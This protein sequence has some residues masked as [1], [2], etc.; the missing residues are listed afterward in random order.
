MA[1]DRP[2]TTEE[3]QKLII[4]Q[5]D[6]I[7]PLLRQALSSGDKVAA[8]KYMNEM[9]RLDQAMRATAEVTVGGMRIPVGQIGSGLQSGISGLLTGLPDIAIGATNLL[10]PKGG[11][12]PSLG[13]LATK[14]L[15]VQNEPASQ[16]TAYPFRIAQGIGSAGIPGT[17]KKGLLLGAALP[18][19][20]VA[21]SQ[22]INLPEGVISGAYA[23]G[24]LTRAGWKGIKDLQE[25][26]KFK[27]FLEDNIPNTND[28]N[29]FKEFMLRGQG[30]DS[31][32][33]AASIQK[34]RSNPEYAELFAKFDKAASDFATKG[35][36]PTTQITGAGAKQQVAESIATRVERQ[37]EG[38]RQQRSE[39]AD[40]IFTQAKGYGGDRA[41]VDSKETISQI[42]KLI[43]DYSKKKTGNADTAVS[44]LSKLRS[45]LVDDNNLPKK[46]TVDET[47]AVLSEFGKNA[48][49]GNSL[50]KDLALTD[51]TRI[52]AA[53]F[54]GLKDDLR[55]A[56]LASKSVEDK[57]A[58]GLLLQA[59][60]QVR[61]AS[62][63]Y[64][65]AIGQGLPAFLKDKPL[66]SISY[67]DIY[68][69][70]KGLNEYQRAKLRAYVGGTDQESL[71]F[72]DRNIFQ[73]FVKSAQ[74]KNDSGVL[75]T[76]LEK[77]ATN[78]KLLGDNEKSSLITA[79]GTNAKEFDQRMAD[80]LTFT[81][82]MKVGK[83]AGAEEDL[84]SQDL[85]RGISASIGAGLG[86]SPSKASDVA[87]I[88][89]NELIKKQG[90]NDEQLMR[91]L[92]TPEGANFLRQGALTGA[93][94]KTLDALTNIPTAAQE[95]MT[96]TGTPS[97]IS[98]LMPKQAPTDQGTDGVYVPEELFSPQTSPQAPSGQEDGVFVPE[99]I[100][101]T[102]PQPQ[103][104]L[105]EQ[106]KNQVLNML[107]ASPNRSPYSNLNPQL[108]P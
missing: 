76:D 75:T 101:Q 14:Y 90:L 40:R 35:M 7:R 51:E 94:A 95:L 79:L 42:D 8:E 104:N 19:G 57:A 47:Q 15:G 100:F 102:N 23:V 66:S 53:I 107:G 99:D 34:L 11:E 10:A 30:S 71:N 80:A 50:V 32:I 45:R 16:E 22:A 9:Q 72:L 86:Y 56:R 36:T 96:K 41:I 37:I 65:E 92:L 44:F 54:G 108:Q 78:W 87:M 1:T 28:Q 48:T 61:K 24:S 26:K 63:E 55:N 2:K 68:S 83:V 85:K 25:S 82:R 12:I 39:S 60:D 17:G 13:G 91:V 27:Q 106:D 89:I 6:A 84:I 88:G 77:L 105:T 98:R 46:L 81:R 38:L 43:G 74:G 20:D 73:D 93:S 67:E 62:D 103:N 70:Y 21:V 64:N 59:R 31:P 18:V 33:V 58:T 5:K 4:Q 97:A 69:N 3:A 52:S 49:L 29:V